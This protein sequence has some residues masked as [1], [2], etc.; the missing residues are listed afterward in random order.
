[1]S[2]VI[3]PK[4]RNQDLGIATLGEGNWGSGIEGADIDPSLFR[5]HT[6]ERVT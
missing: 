2:Y 1:M 5:Y 4:K 3:W 6:I